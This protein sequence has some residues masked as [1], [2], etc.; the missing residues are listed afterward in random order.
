MTTTHLKV[1]CLLIDHQKRT[2]LLT[3]FSVRV[4]AETS[5][6][7]LKGTIKMKL[8]FSRV[9]DPLIEVWKCKERTLLVTETKKQLSTRIEQMD[10]NN[11][12]IVYEVPIPTTMAALNLLAN[13]IL[14]VHISC[15]FSVFISL[16]ES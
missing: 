15:T 10:F 8:G 7:D 11:E 1:S 2:T 5:V 6:E 14:L 16:P 9:P 3:P 4:S 12:D 13:E